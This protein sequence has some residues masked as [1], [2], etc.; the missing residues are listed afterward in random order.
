[1]KLDQ[2]LLNQGVTYDP[3]THEYVSASGFRI[4]Y[5]EWHDEPPAPELHT[6]Y[7]DRESKTFRQLVT[8]VEHAGY[9]SYLHVL[10]AAVNRLYKEF[11]ANEAGK[12][13]ARELEDK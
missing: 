9:R 8:L 12:P 3:A 2:N 6:L 1:M 4:A 10:S 5:D 7:I 11:L 13:H